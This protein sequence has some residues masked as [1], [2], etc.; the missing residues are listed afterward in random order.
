MTNIRRSQMAEAIFENLTGEQAESAGIDPIGKVDRNAVIA[1]KEIGIDW[2]WKESKK[3]TEKMLEEA[4]KIVTF[5]CADKLPEKY[6]L[7]IEDWEIGVTRKTGEKPPAERS[8]D[9]L[10][11]ARDLIYENVKKLVEKLRKED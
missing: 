8:L 1:L 7:K 10:R 2:K 3:V 4:D 11:I 5:R 9:Q 6:K